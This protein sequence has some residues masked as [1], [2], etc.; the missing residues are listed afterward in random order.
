MVNV[1]TE[2]QQSICLGEVY[3]MFSNA[4]I[5]VRPSWKVFHLGSL[6]SPTPFQKRHRLKWCP[7]S[8]R[9]QQSKV[10]S[11]FSLFMDSSIK[12]TESARLDLE[13]SRSGKLIQSKVKFYKSS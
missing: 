12:F 4:T 10:S 8:L 9:Y 2:H 6:L 1:S 3:R 11:V 13:Y 5:K 7:P